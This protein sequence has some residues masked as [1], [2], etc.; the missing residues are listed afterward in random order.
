[1]HLLKLI[2]SKDQE[3]PII[4]IIGQQQMAHFVDVNGDEEV[5]L[6]PYVDMLRRCEESERKMLFVHKQCDIHQIPLKKAR[7]VE[8]LTEI[9][10]AFA[11]DRKTSVQGLFDVI[12]REVNNMDNFINE[13]SDNARQMREEMNHL[14]EYYTVLKRAGEMIFGDN[15]IT[16]QQP[17][18]KLTLGSQKA[19]DAPEEMLLDQKRAGGSD[20]EHSDD[21]LFGSNNS[22][23][24]GP[25]RLAT[26]SSLGALGVSIAYVS[27]TINHTEQRQFEKLIFRA[28]RGKVLTRFHDQSFTIKDH[29]GQ[30]KTKSVYVLVYQE[31]AQM[32]DRVNRVCQSF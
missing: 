28:S 20:S 32:R 1:M 24:Q 5:F 15:E 31:G 10:Q 17:D 9:T 8:Q 29:D 4:D 27:G 13:Q 30:V 21:Y 6:L 19:A 11:E 2:M 25:K 18:K 26:E 7:T 14:I 16:S 3:Y 22:A 23:G 12:D